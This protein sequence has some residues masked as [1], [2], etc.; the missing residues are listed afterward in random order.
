VGSQDATTCLVAIVACPSSRLVWAAHLDDLQLGS[1]DVQRLADALQQMQQ[2]ELYLAGAYS[3]PAGRGPSES[4]GAPPKACACMQGTGACKGGGGPA[5]SGTARIAAAPAGCCRVR[6]ILPAAAVHAGCEGPGAAVLCGRRKH[7][8]RRLPRLLPAGT[9]HADLDAAAVA[10]QGQ[11]AGSAQALRG[12]A[13]QVRCVGLANAYA[14]SNS[15]LWLLRGWPAL[16]THSK[17]R[18]SCSCK[19]HSH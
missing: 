1:A 8:R 7:G 6:A 11:G 15:W 16:H 3:E 10:V 13:L 18:D 9:R 12:A 19:P 4:G 14:T 2:P 5:Y 17:Q